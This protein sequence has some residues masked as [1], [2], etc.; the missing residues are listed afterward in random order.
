MSRVLAMDPTVELWWIPKCD[1]DLPETEQLKIKY[2]NLSARQEAEI[3]D[4]QIKSLTKG[5]TSSYEYRVSMADLK[6]CELTISG[7]EGLKYPPEHPTKANMDC[8]FSK[9]NVGCIPPN[10]RS[11]FVDFITK[12][13]EMAEDEEEA[14]ETTLGEAT[15]E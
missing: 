3:N 12:R 9:E 7:W 10:I 4:Q 13:K 15:P 11:E 5:K 2:K 8:P 6:R 14:S 1:R